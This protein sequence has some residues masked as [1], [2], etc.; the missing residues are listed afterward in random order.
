MSRSHRRILLATIGIVLALYC[1]PP[2]AHAQTVHTPPWLTWLGRGT[3]TWQCL[4]GTCVLNDEVWFG[5]F[6]IGA[7]ATLLN[8]SG[9]G[10]VIVRATGTCTIAGTIN[11]SAN[12][13]GQTG[14]TGAGDFGGGGG[15]GGGG[16]GA[17][18][19]GR[20]TQ[21]ILNVPLVNGGLGGSSGGG[22]GG[23]GRSTT[24]N[25]YQMF[26][27]AGSDW[28][29]GGGAGG[30]G[31]NAGGAAGQGGAPVI[32]ACN[33]ID[34]TGT[35]NATGSNGGAAAANGQ[36]GGGGGGGGYV[37]LAAKTFT[38]TSG[39]ILV[40]GGTG[41]GC[42]GF[43]NCGPGGNGGNGWSYLLTIQ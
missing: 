30:R 42:N 14:I 22:A 7:G 25:Q 18:T 31:A 32:I 10:P 33:T 19:A 35:I 23:N 37:L 29:G 3:N 6:T 12:Y 27:S 4:S 17:G 26:I 13:P 5:N 8:I 2:T 21:V 15:G 39:T 36:G 43:S 16:A 20:T 9:N 41:G 11:T 38:A 34:F 40:N 1:I 28:P 24:I